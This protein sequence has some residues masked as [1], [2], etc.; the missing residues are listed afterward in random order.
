MDGGVSVLFTQVPILETLGGLTTS[1][2]VRA[3][4]FLCVFLSFGCCTTRTCSFRLM[5]CAFFVLGFARMHVLVWGLSA[6]G[7][8]PRSF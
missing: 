5:L 8:R 6:A 1:R 7:W 3:A 4:R 2:R